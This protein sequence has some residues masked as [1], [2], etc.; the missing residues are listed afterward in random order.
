MDPKDRSK[1]IGGSDAAGVLGMSRWDTPL[2]VWAEKT[3]QFKKPEVESEAAELGRELEDYVAKRFARKTGKTVV[4]AESTFF[5]PDHSFLGANVDRLIEGEDA[6]LEC[7]TAS[8]WKSKEWEGEEIPQEYILQCYHYMMVTGK[9]KWYIAVLIGNQDFKWKEIDWDDKFITSL[10]ER[11]IDFWKNYVIP[12][13]MP[14]IT[15]I[16]RHDTDTLMGLFPTAS[17]GKE[18]E[19][20][21]DANL[22]VESLIAL[23]QDIKNCE[24]QI[25]LHENILKRLL[26]DAEVGQT[27]MYR[28]GWTNSRW[29]GLDQKGLKLAYPD[30][31]LKFMQTKAVRKFGYKPLKKEKQ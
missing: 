18:V 9:K 26:E 13:V 31:H 30:V 12:K 25:E 19:L 29:S 2:S 28:I 6:G 27:S 16:T 7:K 15:A 1:F 4:R 23:K 24:N 17:E 11:E 14:G 20:E 3:G 22:A 5:H 8:S 10:Q 21:D